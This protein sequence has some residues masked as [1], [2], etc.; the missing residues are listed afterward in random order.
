MRCV[1]QHLH[2]NLP[3]NT[4]AITP[5]DPRPLPRRQ[6]EDVPLTIVSNA[7]L[8]EFGAALAAAKAC[9]I[10]TETVYSSRDPNYV[11]GAL[12]VISAATRNKDGTDHA[13]VIDVREV[14]ISQLAQ[15]LS[16]VNA[17]AWN[18]NFDSFVIER[19]VIKPALAIASTATGPTG[20]PIT[21]PPITAPPITGPL[22]W[23]AMLADAL[24]HQGLSGF[25]FYHSLAW[26]SEWYLGLHA[27]GKGT[28][29]I[30]FTDTDELSP[31]QLQYAAADAIETLWVGQIVRERLAEAE[32]EQICEL[33]QSARPL[34]AQMQRTGLAIDQDAW[35]SELNHMETRRQE[36]MTCLANLTGGGQADLF[37][38]Q[39]KPN[40]NLNSEYDVRHVLNR[41]ESDRVRAWME[42]EYGASRLLNDADSMNGMTL[43]AIGGEICEA[44]L[45]FRET[46]KIVS[47]YGAGLLALVQPDG[48]FH[49]NYLQV[50]GTNTGR[51]ASRN[52]NAQNLTPRIKPYILPAPGCVFVYGDLSQAELRFA[53]QIAGDKRLQEAFEQGEDIHD[54]TATNMFALDMAQLR[55]TDARQHELMR[56]KAKR[57]NFGILYGLRGAGLA[58]TL[59]E[60]GVATTRR[61][62]DQLIDTYLTTYPGIGAWVNE[63]DEFIANLAA[64]SP[65]IS[66]P[67]TLRL[68]ETWFSV[69]QTRRQLRAEMSRH[70]VVEEVD[71]RLRA[72]TT[73]EVETTSLAETAW[74]LSFPAALVLGADGKPLVITSHTLA[75]RRQQFTLRTDSLL[76]A[77]AEI[78]ANSTKP[79]PRR[80]WNLAL[81]RVGVAGADD[82]AATKMLENRPLRRAV[83]DAIG[84]VMGPDNQAL[85]LDRA[86]RPRIE[87]LT[88]AYRNAPI[89]GGVADV[90]LDVFARLH[91]QL[92]ELDSS[93]ASAKAVQTV[94]DSVVV[95][96]L[97]SDGEKVAQL[98]RKTMEEA[99]RYWCPDVPAVADVDIRRSLA[100]KDIISKVS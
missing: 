71:A 96:C 46:T 62:A 21:S 33:E 95:E 55:T 86:L 64:S 34:L 26:A 53:A 87:L 27:Q 67:L 20:P 30:S 3:E 57:I 69:D 97:E 65:P 7:D 35:K 70:Y 40:W 38:N 83:I 91:S 1:G 99:M 50:V 56:T 5:F 74:C 31:A 60:D 44:L 84:E 6:P 81:Q 58:R 61:E 54:S 68:H 76:G 94:H 14:D 10:D 98:V 15:A 4:N 29:Q 18:A 16:G 36:L 100:D 23:D 77:A 63:R 25:D 12:R 2:E 9:A 42:S 22:W 88:N 48:R 51:L 52:P 8:A 90:M 79:D 39:V 82:A 89:Q 17:D 37:D 47:T 11:I 41:L 85:L 45:A 92:A 32:L 75:G 73:V 13:W 28:T 19:D 66:W 49:S 43:N 72:D 78:V 59:T 24:L 80:A 93:D